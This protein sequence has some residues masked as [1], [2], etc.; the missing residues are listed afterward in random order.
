MRPNT[1]RKRK[2]N[3]LAMDY[4]ALRKRINEIKIY[5]REYCFSPGILSHSL[6]K[7][8]KIKIQTNF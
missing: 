7:K 2:V 5:K 8:K 4:D 1:Y 6:V 3:E